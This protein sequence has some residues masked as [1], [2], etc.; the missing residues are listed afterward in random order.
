MLDTWQAFGKYQLNEGQ[1]HFYWHRE[2]VHNI[3]F[4]KRKAPKFSIKWSHLC[5]YIMCVWTQKE[6]PERYPGKCSRW[7]FLRR[8]NKL[9]SFQM[10]YKDHALF[11]YIPKAIYSWK[12]T[13]LCTL[14][15][16]HTAEACSW[17]SVTRAGSQDGDSP[18]HPPPAWWA[19]AH[20]HP[21]I[22]NTK[23]I[24]RM[25]STGSETQQCLLQKNSPQKEMNQKRKT[26]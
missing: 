26:L 13:H 3:V 1:I 21:S 25:T 6:N 24:H 11:L 8:R 7:L 2:N 14:M 12:Q 10:F 22:S 4:S 19:T 16:R 17:L 15:G 18:K 5:K 9:T 20:S 23:R